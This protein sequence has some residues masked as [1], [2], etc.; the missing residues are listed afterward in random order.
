MRDPVVVCL[1]CTS[2]CFQCARVCELLV[3]RTD[4]KLPCQRSATG[5]SS[6][7]HS[8]SRDDLA[9]VARALRVRL[10]CVGISMHEHEVEYANSLKVWTYFSRLIHFKQSARL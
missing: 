6:L 9:L 7:A 8:R 5:G 4:N 10:K 1:L 2:Q 3:R